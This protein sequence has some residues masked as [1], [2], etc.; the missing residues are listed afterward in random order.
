[1]AGKRRQREHAR[2]RR[3]KSSVE[4][5]GHNRAGRRAAAAQARRGD[6]GASTIELA[7]SV[8]AAI[9][10][11]NERRERVTIEQ[12]RADIESGYE[13]SAIWLNAVEWPADPRRESAR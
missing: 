8:W 12:V 11:A 9:R 4:P 1:M 3:T 6:A 2:V 10:R 5:G 7:R 13:Q